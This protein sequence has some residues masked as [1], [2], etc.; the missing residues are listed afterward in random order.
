M[1]DELKRRYD[2]DSWHGTRSLPMNVLFWR[3]RLRGTELPGWN[4]HT[5]RA[6]TLAP[7]GRFLP[8]VWQPHGGRRGNALRVDGYECGSREAAHERLVRVL[9]EFTAPIMQRRT[10]VA[11]GD[12]HFADGNGDAVLFS[13]ANLVFLLIGAGHTRMPV[14]DLAQTLDQDLIAVPSP[15]APAA[16]RALRTTME[17]VHLPVGRPYPIPFN[18]Q[19]QPDGRANALAQVTREQAVAQY[20]LFSQSCELFIE[21]DKVHAVAGKVGRHS[22]EIFALSPTG[23]WRRRDLALEATQE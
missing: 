16:P 11:L 12:V 8:S 13:R 6:V 19:P 10:D 2:Y 22:I 15:A 7:L 14:I 5:T 23:A 20:K 17:I 18:E 9:G 4:V 21:Q 1:Y 3:Y